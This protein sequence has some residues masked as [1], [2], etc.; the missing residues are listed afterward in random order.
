METGDLAT[1]I[2]SAVA[3]IAVL[4]AAYERHDNRKLSL[5]NRELEESRHKLEVAAWRHSHAES[6]RT[7]ADNVCLTISEARHMLPLGEGNPSDRVAILARLSS[8]ID[9]GR[10]YFPNT[11]V[12]T[13]GIE[14]EPAYRG[15]RQPVL[16][17]VVEAY[18]TLE[19]NGDVEWKSARLLSCQRYFVSD[20]QKAI[21]PAQRAAEFKKFVDLMPRP[22][23]KVEAATP[24]Q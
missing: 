12:D 18:R 3:F 21:N 22:E 11:H 2:A 5:K 1:W 9:T 13:V 7:W 15:Y 20:I 4:F 19:A 14:K 10:W 24:S 8:L 6:I 17:C 16:D 23:R